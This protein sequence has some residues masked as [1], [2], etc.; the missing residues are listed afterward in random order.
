MVGTRAARPVPPPR[1]ITMLPDPLSPVTTGA[2]LDERFRS[3]PSL[4]R[5]VSLLGRELDG[6]PAF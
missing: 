5:E 3:K 6:K 1:D 2:P 4:A